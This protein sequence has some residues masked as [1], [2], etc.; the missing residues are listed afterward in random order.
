[1]QQAVDSQ[2]EGLGQDLLILVFDIRKVV[3]NPAS[4]G[5]QMAMGRESD[6]NQ[7]LLEVSHGAN[8]VESSVLL[9]W[10]SASCLDDRQEKIYRFRDHFLP[11][12]AS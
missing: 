2:P 5:S 8:H 7:E 10:S 3:K 9:A 11:L 6:L 12:L 1:V 4:S